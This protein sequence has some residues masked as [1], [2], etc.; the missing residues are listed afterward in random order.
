MP[1]LQVIA[2]RAQEQQGSGPWP[3]KK[4]PAKAGVTSPRGNCVPPCRATA[5]PS[6]RTRPPLWACGPPPALRRSAPPASHPESEVSTGHDVPGEEKPGFQASQE[7]AGA[8]FGTSG[9]VRAGLR[10]FCGLWLVLRLARL[11]ECRVAGCISLPTPTGAACA[12]RPVIAVLSNAG[13]AAP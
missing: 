8:A 13:R 3:P 9:R 12:A 1:G 10:E 11:D 5:S 2:L 4:A 7:G 6:H